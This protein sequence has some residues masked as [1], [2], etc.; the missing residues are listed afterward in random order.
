MHRLIIVLSLASLAACQRPE[1]DPRLDVALSKLESIDKRL[2]N[3][4]RRPA[5]AQGAA[6]PQRPRADPNTV[7]FLPVDDGDHVIGPRHAKVTIVEAFEFACPHCY[8]TSKVMAQVHEKYPRDVRIVG[9]QYIIHPDIATL[10]ALAACAANLQ[11]KYAAFHDA[12]WK[13]AWSDSGMNREALAA[14]SLEKL[15]GEV[16]L[17][18]ARFKKDLAGDVCKA[19]LEENRRL[20]PAVGV[21][22]TPA[23]YINGKPYQGPRSLEAI[24]AAIDQEIAAADKAAAAGTRVE[25]YYAT[26]MKTAKKSL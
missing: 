18:V 10:P 4:E 21:T 24:S 2:A 1:R 26:L 8:T 7:Y 23:I 3:L 20:L 14:A 17:D 19:D 5:G 9:K 16:G 11:G 13:R 25:D 12:L 22:G 15:A 6:M